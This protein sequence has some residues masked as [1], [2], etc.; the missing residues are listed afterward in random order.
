[1]RP[2]FFIWN[3]IHS[4][5]VAQARHFFSVAYVALILVTI[6]SRGAPRCDTAAGRCPSLVSI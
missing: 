5:N 1:M 3:L 2:A 6:P 4:A